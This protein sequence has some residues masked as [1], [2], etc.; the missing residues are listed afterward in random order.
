MVK[1]YY[2][3]ITG[4]D[5]EIG[6]IRDKLEELDIADNTIIIFMGDNGYFLGERKLAGKWLMYD[7][8]LRVPLIVYD[9]HSGHGKT[10]NELA[11]NIDIA[12]TILHYAG[13]KKPDKME[14]DN[15][16]KLVG[17]DNPDWRSIFLCEHLFD[18]A[19]IPKSEGVR[20]AD[21]KYFKYID[22]PEWEEL[23][24]LKNDPLE[25][26]NLVNETSTRS[27]LMKLRQELD[28]LNR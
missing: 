2:R 13:I 26:N 27:I 17:M 15:L 8:C 12:P 7:H 28:T 19:K 9:P 14:G 4:I 5:R 18:H 11:L 21:W 20:T 23:Y 16:M 3:M 1:A 6:R 24:D 25:T 10:L 22:H